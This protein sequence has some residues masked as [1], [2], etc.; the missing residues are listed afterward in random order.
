M[1]LFTFE[2]EVNPKAKYS[3]EWSDIGGAYVNCYVSFKNFEIAEKIANW[4]IRDSGWIVRKRTEASKLQKSKLT[5][6]KEIQY[7]AEALKYGYCLVFYTWPADE[8]KED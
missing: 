6:K 4:A 2:A 1:F 3:A 7:Y 8:I 5:T